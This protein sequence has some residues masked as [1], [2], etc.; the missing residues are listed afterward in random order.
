MPGAG[1]FIHC[2]GTAASAGE[3]ET[4][5]ILVSPTWGIAVAEYQEP[6][7]KKRKYWKQVQ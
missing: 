1:F 6:D 7:G 3:D 5:T 4:H 2:L